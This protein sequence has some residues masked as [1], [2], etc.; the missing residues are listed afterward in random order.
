MHKQVTPDQLQSWL[1]DPVTKSYL[2]SMQYCLDKSK[3]HLASGKCVVPGN[4]D[5]SH[6]NHAFMS[7]RRDTLIETLDP[8]EF[9]GTY[10]RPEV[11][12]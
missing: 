2:D 9:L 6:Y 8:K 10:E 12:A 3:E 1:A 11:V 7:G 5:L 4:S